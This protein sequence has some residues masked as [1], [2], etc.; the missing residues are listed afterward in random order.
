MSRKFK[1]SPV[2][3]AILMLLYEAPIHPYRMQQLIKERGKDKVINVERRASLYQYIRQLER[4]GMIAVR[5]TERGSRHPDRTIYEL[6]ELGRRTALEW[7]RSALSTP[8]LEYPEFPAAVSFLAVLAPEDALAQFKARQAALE[9]RLDEIRKG[10]EAYATSL[11][12]LFLLEDE[13][14]RATL[15]AELIWLRSVI[16]DLRSGELTWHEEW[17]RRF[18]LQQVE[19]SSEPE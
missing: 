12:R 15:E 7:L 11:P 13:L 4:A 1:R 8:S 10:F 19:D 18:G 3:L 17:L 2:V 16:R 14:V 5:K 6:T 9:T